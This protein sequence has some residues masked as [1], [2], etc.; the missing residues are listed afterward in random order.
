M[1]ESDTA[2]VSVLPFAGSELS[3]V[4]LGKVTL[5]V[6]GLGVGPPCLQL[7]SEEA[8]PAL[9]DER[10]EMS[11]A[12]PGVTP[13]EHSVLG[14]SLDGGLQECM[15]VLEPLEHSVPAITWIDGP[16][17]GTPVLEPLEHS[18]LEKSSHD[19]PMEGAPVLEPLE[20]SVLKKPWTVDRWREYQLWTYSSILLWDRWSIRFWRRLWTFGC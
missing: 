1:V 3:A 18:V 5:D 12:V 4:F 16:M 10:G 2:L 6:V 9:L 8:L 14:K 17:K 13:I 15:P 11:F 20:H 7:D 19:E